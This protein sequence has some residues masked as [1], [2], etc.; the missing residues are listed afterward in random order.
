MRAPTYLRKP[1]LLACSAAL[2][3]MAAACSRQAGAT[4]SRVSGAQEELADP[5]LAAYRAELLAVAFEAASAMPRVPHLKNRSR[6]QEQ[7][8]QACL[9]LDQ[10]R[11]AATFAKGIEDWRRGTAYADVA[12][13]RARHGDRAQATR[14]IDLAR[15]VAD[16]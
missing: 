5:P 16:L 7:V 11:C 12:S 8:V 2:L 15:E 3:L 6:A 10:P 4:E 13:H 9:E 14:C 1:V